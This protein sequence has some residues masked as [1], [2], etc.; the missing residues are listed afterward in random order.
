MI[1]F[2][3]GQYTEQ[4]AEGVVVS[5]GGMGFL[6]RVSD[7]T[8]GTLPAIGADVLLKT[9]L[10]VREDAMDLY[11]FGDDDER[12]LFMQ[13]VGV[14]GIGPRMALAICGL[15]SPE[16]LANAIRGGEVATLTQAAGVGKKTAERVIL[17]LRDKVGTSGAIAP[18]PGSGPRGGARDGLLALGFSEAEVDQALAGAEEGLDE[19]RLIRFGL[20]AL[21][22]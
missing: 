12:V 11:G 6:V 3:R 13:L 1:R 4:D 7:H 9:H 2:V 16:Q 10:A 21:G 22:R 14:S 17:E 8:R 5:M 20:A 18:A 19:E 15:T